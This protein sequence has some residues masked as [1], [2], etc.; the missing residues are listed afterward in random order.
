MRR[1]SQLSHLVT[2][3]KNRYNLALL[4][5]KEKLQAHERAIQSLEMLHRYRQ[6]YQLPAQTLPIPVGPFLGRQTFIENLN[7]TIREQS[8]VLTNTQHEL[9]LAQQK[10]NEAYQALRGVELLLEKE[11]LLEQQEK[12]KK[13]NEELEESIMVRYGRKRQY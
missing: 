8:K 1:K 4:M 7:I 11:C 12:R 6:E 3:E 10:V 2:I 5:L 13:E 9:N